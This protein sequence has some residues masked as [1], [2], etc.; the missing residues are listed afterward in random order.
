MLLAS[1]KVGVRREDVIYP[2]QHYRMESRQERVRRSFFLFLPVDKKRKK[3]TF[4]PCGPPSDKKEL[5]EEKVPAGRCC[6]T[7]EITNVFLKR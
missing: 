1:E 3:K 6:P 4:I 5:Y 7:Q 2:H